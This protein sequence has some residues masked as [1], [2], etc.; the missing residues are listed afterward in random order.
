MDSLLFI[1]LLVIIFIGIPIGIGF[2]FYFIPKKLGY[3]RVAR[4]LTIVYSL[5][6]L[7]VAFLVIFQDELFTKNDAKELV[8]D[9]GF[10]LTDDFHLL[11]NESSSGI[12]DY[13]HTFI[14]RISPRDKQ[15]AITK[16]IQSK[17]FKPDGKALKDLLY[18][19][20]NRYFGPKSTQNYET[21]DAYVREY[22]QPGGRKVMRLHSGVSR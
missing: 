8:N 12:G 9:Q 14:L 13:Y 22:F 18:I 5:I 11:K 16:I 3:P 20:T 19:N 15:E 21:G 1:G 7:A 2:L 17:N 6:I 10:K 4:Y